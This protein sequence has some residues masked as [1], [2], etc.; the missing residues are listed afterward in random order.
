MKEQNKEYF[1][2]DI[3]FWLIL[4]ASVMLTIMILQSPYMH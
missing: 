1:Y 3:R 4:S 2:Q